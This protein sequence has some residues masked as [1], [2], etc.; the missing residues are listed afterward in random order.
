[1]SRKEQDDILIM[2]ALKQDTL[3]GNHEKISTGF[4]CMDYSDIQ[5]LLHQHKTLLD[6]LGTTPGQKSNGI[7][8]IAY[9]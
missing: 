1:M 5:Q 6:V 2:E 4:N 7:T 3:N 9:E 8:R